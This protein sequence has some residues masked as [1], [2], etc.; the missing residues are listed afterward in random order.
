MG[1][2]GGKTH[3]AKKKKSSPNSTQ[4]VKAAC[5]WLQHD[6]QQRG[7]YIY[8]VESDGNC[9]FRALV[10]QLDGTCPDIADHA[11]LRALVVDT[12]ERHKEHFEAFVE[13]DE[14]FEDYITRM[15]EDGTWGGQLEIQAASWKLGVNIRIYQD[16]MVPWTVKN[17][18]DERMMLHVS[19]HDG[20][21]YNSLRELKSGMAVSRVVGGQGVYSGESQPNRSTTRDNK[22]QQNGEK[23]LPHANIE[24][25]ILLESRVLSKFKMNKKDVPSEQLM[26]VRIR[27][28]GSHGICQVV[29]RPVIL[30]AVGKKEKVNELHGHGKCQC[31][32]G[33][34]YKKCCKGRMRR[35]L[36]HDQTKLSGVD[37]DVENTLAKSV[38]SIYL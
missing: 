27:V 19:Y 11:A 37:Q 15:K 33:K 29:I 21:H 17:F 1:K 32:S 10:D 20:M 18:D 22:E 31:G 14:S 6:L 24:S 25:K 16:G 4:R 36:A 5:G 28:L 2:K 13:D 3:K 35:Q 34:K 38:S 23:P 8:E 12:M 30:H 7:W 9:L 26:R